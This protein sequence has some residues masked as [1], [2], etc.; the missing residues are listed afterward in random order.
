MAGKVEM[1]EL[2]LRREERAL[3]DG[4][5]LTLWKE[6]EQTKVFRASEFVENG[7]LKEPGGVGSRP[8]TPMVSASS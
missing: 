5:P 1:T 3:N 6:P 7:R 8:G 2:A 4:K